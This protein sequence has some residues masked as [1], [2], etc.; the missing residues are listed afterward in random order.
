MGTSRRRA[1]SPEMDDLHRR[2]NA[3]HRGLLRVHK[4]VLDH[5]RLR[6]E[7]N[8]GPVGSPLEF[9]QLVLRD[10]WFAWLR[11][12]SE[13]TVQID[14]FTSSREPTDPNHGEALLKQA[15][16]LLVP[17]ENGDGFAREYHRAIQEST[18]VAMTH[19]EWRKSIAEN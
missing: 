7:R 10:P 19:G 16:D 12:V 8:R 18:E 6:Y 13:L 2:L 14:E 17:M 15:R 11:P 5:E 3:A 1:L 4:A 9:L